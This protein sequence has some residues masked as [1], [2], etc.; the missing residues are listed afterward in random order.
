MFEIDLLSKVVP[1]K[2]SSHKAWEASQ[3]DVLKL[4]WNEATIGPSPLVLKRLAQVVK[5]GRM[6]WYPDVDNKKLRQKIADYCSVEVENVQFFASSDSLHEYI[7]RCFVGLGDKT[8]IV[9]P[10]YD[11]FRAVAQA[12]GADLIYHWLNSDFVLDY[13]RLRMDLVKFAPKIVYIVNPNNPTGSGHDVSVLER[14]ILDFP[15][16]LFIVD[17]AYYEFYGH[18][19]SELVSKTGNLIVTRTFSKAFA[20]ASFRVG[21]VISSPTIVDSLNKIRNAK[22]V[23]LFAQVAAEAVLDDLPY[24]ENYVAEVIRAKDWFLEALQNLT[25]LE[26]IN[27]YGNFILLKFKNRDEKLGLIVFLENRG[28]Y[29]RDYAHLVGMEVYARVTIGTLSEMQR[30]YKEFVEF[31]NSRIS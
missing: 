14:V 30:V 4:D 26:T 6:N 2:L 27:S 9:S 5:S 1:Y 21:Y 23:S 11:N 15:K 18:T 8:M 22:N 7:V 17:E 24:T 12:N 19:I 13:G 29:I 20:L 16:V 28:I 31:S 3:G 25:F 10:T